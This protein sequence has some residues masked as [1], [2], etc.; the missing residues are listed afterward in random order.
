MTTKQLTRRQ[1]RWAE[2]MGCF[3]FEIIF[4]PG[5]RSGKPDALSRRPDL[6]PQKEDK[7]SFGQL[8]KPENIT[9]NTFAELMDIEAWLED[10]TVD[11]D[12]AEHWFNIDIVGV[13]DPT[14]DTLIP[15]DIELINRTRELTATD[16]RLKLILANPTSKY[17]VADGLVY[18]NGRIVVPSNNELKEAILRSRHDSKTAGHPGRARTFQLV[19]RVFTWASLK[20]FTNQYVDGC[21]SCLRVKS[22]TQRPLGM[23]EPLP[24][25]AGPW[26]DISYDMITDLPIANGFDSIL[27]VIDRL[28]K[29]VHFIPCRKDMNSEELADIMLRNVWRLHGTP[30]TIVSDRGSIFISQITQQ[31][32]KRLGIRLQPSTAYHP[33]TDG[34]SEI[35]NKAVEQFLRHFVTY[36]Q[37][38]W[39]ALIPMAEFSYNNNNHTSI[40]MS[41]FRANYGFNPAIT[42]TPSSEQCVPA[43][44]QRMASFEKLQ[45]EITASL[46][47]AQESMKI[48]FNR[49]V[50]ETPTWKVGDEVWLNSR[51]IATTRPSPK[52]D[53]RWLGPFTIIGK[54]SESAYRLK[55]PE[56]MRQVHPVFHV[57]Q[58]R[59]HTPD[60]ISGRTQPEPTPLKINGSDEWEV[61]DILDRREIRGTLK[62]L[63]SWKGF[64]PSENSWEPEENLDN[65]GA[66]I[67][68]FN[69]RHP[70]I[71]QHKKR[72]R[73]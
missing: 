21:D 64:G 67:E 70:N 50:N 19:R 65:C 16:E 14:A 45:S 27:T 10:E 55:L 7:L 51:N 40:G 42:G 49:K 41:P 23:L 13:E 44:E 37:D 46:A 15:S 20:R 36:H 56:S 69:K 28:T 47:E 63:V 58:L 52:L 4:R 57:S 73:G 24:I 17:S 9:G 22:S 2:T 59:K 11:L 38:D 61:E 25:P 29:M 62:Y 12:D 6:K 35:A 43:V 8:L 18:N 72:R 66:M 71:G 32:S 30:K 60:E 3:D 1:A 5:T 33:R 39:E 31:L 26:T 68:D 54:I 53:H 48:Q 34:Q